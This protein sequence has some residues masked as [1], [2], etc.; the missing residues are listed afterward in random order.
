MDQNNVVLLF[1]FFPIIYFNEIR[2]FTSFSIKLFFKIVLPWKNE[3][4]DFVVT[5]KCEKLCYL[6]LWL[7]SPG[8]TEWHLG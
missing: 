4:A 6:Q 3:V 2:I 1:F 8:L 7:T 5:R